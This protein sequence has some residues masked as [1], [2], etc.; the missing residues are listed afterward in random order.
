MITQRI[1]LDL[2][3]EAYLSVMRSKL[4]IGQLEMWVCYYT[5]DK[6][7]HLNLCKPETFS[8]SS[9]NLKVSIHLWFQVLSFLGIAL[10]VFLFYSLLTVLLEVWDK[11]KTIQM[12]YFTLCFDVNMSV[13]C[14]ASE[15]YNIFWKY[16]LL[17]P[18]VQQC[19]LYHYSQQTCGRFWSAFSLTMRRLAHSVYRTSGNTYISISRNQCMW[20][21]GNIC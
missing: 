21:C 12:T 10:G 18:M 1:F 5:S 13:Y 8:C 20:P 16:G 3:I 9:T 14:L 11:T 15:T 2:S 17:R 19:S 4:F 6:Q 7:F